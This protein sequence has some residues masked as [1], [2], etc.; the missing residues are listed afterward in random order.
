MQ[1]KSA[2][3]S[4]ITGC[5]EQ[6]V[7]VTNNFNGADT[8]VDAEFPVGQTTVIWML[9]AADGSTDSCT[10]TIEV[11]DEEAP[12]L[13]CPSGLTFENAPEDFTATASDNCDETVTVTCVPAT[14]TALLAAAGDTV[15]CT[16]TDSAGNTS[17]CSFTL[18]HATDFDVFAAIDELIERIDQLR[19]DQTLNRGRANALKRKL[20]KARNRFADNRTQPACN[21]MNAFRNQVTAF[22]SNG[23]LPEEDASF[24]LTGADDILANACG[25][26]EEDD[27]DTDGGS[28]EEETDNGGDDS[29]DGDDDN[30]ENEGDEGN[31]G[32]IGVPSECADTSALPL[33]ALPF[34]MLSMKS[35]RRRSRR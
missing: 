35:R 27:S 11:L 18:T 4:L 16:A 8:L 23:H 32:T 2:D 12:S 33:G 19:S 17:T 1:G 5:A 21:K 15:T 10:T 31:G 7:T 9:T 3:L 24:L 29:D 28:T 25:T 14:L 6:A 30:G 34:M 13:T 22:A 26:E 20:T